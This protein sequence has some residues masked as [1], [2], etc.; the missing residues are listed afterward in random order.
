MPD[1]HV[2]EVL[3]SR[4]W[5]APCVRL[6]PPLKGA[7]LP[8]GNTET[9]HG[10]TAIEIQQVV[11]VSEVLRTSSYY[12]EYAVLVLTKESES[13]PDQ[14]SQNKNGRASP[15]SQPLPP[16][17]PPPQ[18]CGYY[19]TYAIT[20]YLG[21]GKMAIPPSAILRVLE[22]SSSNA[23]GFLPPLP[24]PLPPPARPAISLIATYAAPPLSLM[25]FHW[26]GFAWP[27]TRRAGCLGLFGAPWTDL[28]RLGRGR[29]WD[30]RPPW[31]LWDPDADLLFP[32]ASNNRS[33]VQNRVPLI[34]ASIAFAPASLSA[35]FKAAPQLGLIVICP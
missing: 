6:E 28:P 30:G 20:H 27:Q 35:L 33:R 13:R 23:G 10:H 32:L 14:R 34:I 25:S 3:G 1:V 26:N 2:Y 8:H 12:P 19:S 29:D 4:T 22:D 7:A 5:H 21:R 17:P 11:V 16:I 31:Q 24:R 18:S 15:F 9:E